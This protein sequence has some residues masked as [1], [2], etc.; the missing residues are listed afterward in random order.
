MNRIQTEIGEIVS[1]SGNTI[2][3]KL[4]DTIKSNMPVIDGVV[5]RIG[6]IGSFLKVPLGYA[7]LYGIVTQIGASAIPDKLKE[8]AEENKTLLDN[9]Q[10][11]NMVLVGEQMGKKFNR[12][13]SQSPTTGDKVHLVTIKDL[14]II[15]GG[16]EIFSGKVSLFILKYTLS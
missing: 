1:V 11:L 16:F 3:I 15:Y 7:N 12:G 6:Q 5:Y 4:S 2:T 9:R 14:D 10:W 13:V 8:L